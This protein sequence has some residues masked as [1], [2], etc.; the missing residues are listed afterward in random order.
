MLGRMQL[1]GLEEAT[2]P[3]AERF[4]VLWRRG[5]PDPDLDIPSVIM[6]IKVHFMHQSRAL[7]LRKGS[8]RAHAGVCERPVILDVVHTQIGYCCIIRQ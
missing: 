6:V 8:A 4:V 1:D 7:M 3:F 2:V 5:T